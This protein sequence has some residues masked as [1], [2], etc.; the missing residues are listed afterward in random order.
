[1]RARRLTVLVTPAI[2]LSLFATPDGACPEAHTPGVAKEGS[3][4]GGQAPG[5][6]GGG[7]CEK[8]LALGRHA[9]VP[10]R[11]LERGIP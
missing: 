11:R 8:T 2:Y 5:H 1:M 10:T 7:R 9:A 6:A 3:M 4:R